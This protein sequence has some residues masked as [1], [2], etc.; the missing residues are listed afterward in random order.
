MVPR[1]PAATLLVLLLAS[2]VANTATFEVRAS[3]PFEIVDPLGL[4]PFAVPPAG[5]TLHLSFVFDDSV[6]VADTTTSRASYRDG[7]SPLQISLGSDTYTLA[8]GLREIRIT[9][10]CACAAPGIGTGQPYED[11]WEVSQT[12]LRPEQGLFE[13][14]TLGLLTA[15]F[16]S[17]GGPL[18]TTALTAPPAL[19]EWESAVIFFAIGEADPALRPGGRLALI[20]ATP[21]SLAVTSVPGPAALWLLVTALAALGNVRRSARSRLRQ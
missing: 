14:V 11:S 12:S 13:A 21:T 10:D 18:A 4:L 8:D 19:R 3:G 7:I 16:G 9:N 6:A 2:P 15:S 5:T 20:R 17:P 1:L